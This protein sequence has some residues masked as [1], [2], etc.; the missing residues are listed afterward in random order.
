MYSDNFLFIQLSSH[1]F[2]LTQTQCN[3]WI[4][5]LKLKFYHSI[6]LNW[7]HWFFILSFRLFNGFFFMS[8]QS[9][10]MKLLYQLK[11]VTLFFISVKLESLHYLSQRD[12]NNLFS[13]L[14]LLFIPLQ[15]SHFFF[16]LLFNLHLYL[17]LKFLL[18]SLL[19]KF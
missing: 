15:I 19:N 9:V 6:S 11:F 5:S 18:F 16:N 17:V 3:N 10:L 8:N 14:K 4:S 2:N 12:C 13:K 1:T 7:S